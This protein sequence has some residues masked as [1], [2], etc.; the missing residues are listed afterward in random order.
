MPDQLL[1]PRQR[2]VERGAVAVGSAGGIP[3]YV[4]AQGRT[5][6]GM[7]MRVL[8]RTDPDTSQHCTG[9]CAEVWEPLLAPAGSTPNIR[10][11]MGFGDRGRQPNKQ[12]L[13]GDGYGT[14]QSASGG[15][16]SSVRAPQ[17][18]WSSAV[19]AAG[20][21]SV[22]GCDGDPSA[23]TSASAAA[24]PKSTESKAENGR[25]EESSKSLLT[26]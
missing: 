2:G 7:D 23:A 21:P 8:L 17:P 22:A 6:Y 1:E 16:R 10:F 3:V 5:L 9:A 20:V 13:T 25:P 26:R 12:R 4:D 19:T 18:A 24:P 15:G 14:P 11:P